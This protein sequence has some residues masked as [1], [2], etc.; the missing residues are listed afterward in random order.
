M[1]EKTQGWMGPALRFEPFGSYV[2]P[3]ESSTC[4]R[5]YH[6]PSLLSPLRA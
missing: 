2:V 5:N 4:K 3:L 6:Q 1:K